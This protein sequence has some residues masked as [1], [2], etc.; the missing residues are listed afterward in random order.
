MASTS[1]Y[2]G[3]SYT[4]AELADPELPQVII[5]RAELG[6]VDRPATRTEEETSWHQ[7]GGDSIPSGESAPI[8]S[9]K[10]KTSAR[11]RARTTGNHSNQ[12]A[13]TSDADST[14]GNGHETE[15]AS[16]KDDDPFADFN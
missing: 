10:P 3:A 12:T 8:E 7:D 9:D 16:P 5:R 14:D 6:Y 1:K 2:G 15:T 11:K 4:P 13:Q